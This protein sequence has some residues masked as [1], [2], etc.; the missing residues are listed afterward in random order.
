MNGSRNLPFAHPAE[1]SKVSGESQEG[2]VES[3][4]LHG[5]TLLV[6]GSGRRSREPIFTLSCGP[7]QQA[8]VIRCFLGGGM[9]SEAFTPLSVSHSLLHQ[10]LLY[11]SGSKSDPKFMLPSLWVFYVD[12]CCFPSFP[13]ER[14]CWSHV[15]FVLG[16]QNPLFAPCLSL[17]K[18]NITLYCFFCS[19]YCKP[20]DKI[21]TP[22]RG[23]RCFLLSACPHPW[24]V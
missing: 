18:K 24:Q 6:W 5:P 12:Y 15:K 16:R 14:V 20:C 2:T 7:A 10:T 3:S 23:L 19:V 17:T 1:A 21:L 13:P 22:F 8:E 4:F 9:V 11:P